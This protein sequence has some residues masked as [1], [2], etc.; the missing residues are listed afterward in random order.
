MIFVF[1]VYLIPKKYKSAIN[2]HI[3]RRRFI[4]FGFWG[5]ENQLIDMMYRNQYQMK[6][7]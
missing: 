4:W 1:I 7:V 2:I 6:L 5:T 3:D